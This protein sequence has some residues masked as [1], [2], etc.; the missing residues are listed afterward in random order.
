VLGLIAIEDEYEARSV[1][2][3]DLLQSVTIEEELRAPL[4]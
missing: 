2:R 3:I 1:G 4:D